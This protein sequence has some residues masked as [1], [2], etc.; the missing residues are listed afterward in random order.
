MQPKKLKILFLPAWYP[1]KNDAMA[2]LFVKHHAKAVK[3]YADVAVMHIIFNSQTQKKAIAYEYNVDDDIPTLIAYI[4]IEEDNITDKILY[5]LRY[6]IAA[7]IGY[8]KITRQFGT[9]NINHVHIL[10]RS[11]IV[12][13]YKKI[14][15][16]IPYIVTE[17]WSR[18]LPQ[19][20]SSYRGWF[21]KFTTKKVA[22]KA[23]LITTVSKHLG[24][25]MQNHGLTNTYTQISNV[26][27]ID[28]FK[29]ADKK[30]KNA[31]PILLHV[32]C[33]D[34]KPKNVK[35]ILNTLKKLE[36][37]GLDFE[38]RLVGEGIDHADCVEYAKELE[39][40][41]AKFL[42][43]KTGEA[44]L[45]EYQKA[46][47][48][49]LFSRFENQPVVIVEALACGLPVIATDVGGIPELLKD[50]FGE[51]ITS[52]NEEELMLAIKKVTQSPENY[53]S[54]AM[55]QYVL[56]NFSYKGVGKQFY[57]IYQNILQG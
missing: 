18:Y 16:G 12:A 47:T 7:F 32:S 49:I 11:G 39:V 33:F 34:E 5:P 19:N 10:S 54:A 28:F 37:E 56:E 42:G 53:N 50:E 35:G 57:D 46:D 6:I 8:K 44:L 40:K 31:T 27:D 43:L 36:N 4:R 1:N 51:L 55:R 23:A 38:L 9:P 26:V 29:P 22:K 52:M 17:H 15:K 24:I 21:K 25:A 13:L 2:G 20:S 48:F 41:N 45:E 30:E 14:I 3:N